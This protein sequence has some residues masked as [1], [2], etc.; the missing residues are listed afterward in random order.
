M[1]RARLNGRRPGSGRP[2]C[3]LSGQHVL[4]AHFYARHRNDL[5]LTAALFASSR[6][7]LDEGA[8]WKGFWPA[9]SLTALALLAKPVAAVAL[10][11]IGALM[12]RAH[13]L[14]TLRRAQTYSFALVVL[15]PWLVYDRYIS[16]IAEWHWASGIMQ[17]HVIPSLHTALSSWN[18]LHQALQSYRH[19]LDMLPG[20]MLG[21]WCAALFACAILVP[22]QTRSRTFLFAFLAAC[23]LYSFVVMRYERVDY[24]FYVLLPLAALWSGLLV[25]RLAALVPP[26]AAPRW[27]AGALALSATFALVWVN[28]EPVRAYYHYKPQTYR[29]AKMLD[30]TLAPGSLVVV[31]HYDPSVQ[32]YINRK[33]WEEDPYLWTPFNEQS[34][35][36]KGAR[37]FI[38]IEKNR[39]ERNVEL[40]AWLQRFPVL[41][42]RAQWPIYQTDYAKMLPGSE[43]RWQQ[44][45]KRERAR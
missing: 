24:Y 34:A 6:W 20:T 35:I 9:A 31:G 28:R 4:R 44:F 32:Y 36:R 1:A 2:L 22:Q 17:L 39:L 37:Y 25:D 7:I 19:V 13:G 38:A 40:H 21:P 41:N 42:P 3:A 23:L 26:S 8:G 12:L 43:Q 15:L 16:S 10:L 29:N 33:G 14:A 18:E 11:P 45:R 5:F 27:T 30:A